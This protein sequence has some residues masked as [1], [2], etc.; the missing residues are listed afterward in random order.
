MDDYEYEKQDKLGN[1]PVPHDPDPVVFLMY[2]IPADEDEPVEKTVLRES[3]DGAMSARMDALQYAVDGYIDLLPGGPYKY[4]NEECD[5]YVDDEGLLKQDKQ[6]NY[7]AMS[8]VDWRGT[9]PL[10]GDIAFVPTRFFS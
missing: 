8:L 6:P 2:T 5:V 3:E 10:V 9:Y 7:R 4:E 1:G